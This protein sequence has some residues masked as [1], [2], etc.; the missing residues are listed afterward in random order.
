[1]AEQAGRLQDATGGPR[2]KDENVQ[3]IVIVWP[4]RET[5]NNECLA[6]VSVSRH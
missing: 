2:R 5:C 4:A 3:G 1:M 6:G